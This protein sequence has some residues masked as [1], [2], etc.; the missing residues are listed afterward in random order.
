MRLL[1]PNCFVCATKQQ[2]ADVACHATGVI[3][4]VEKGAGKLVEKPWF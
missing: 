2:F 3:Y 1:V 4:T